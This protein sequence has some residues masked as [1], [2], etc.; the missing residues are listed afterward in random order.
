MVVFMR[1]SG[2][3]ELWKGVRN[4]AMQI[5]TDRMRGLVERLQLLCVHLEDEAFVPIGTAFS[6]VSATT[7]HDLRVV[8]KE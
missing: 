6:T 5:A 1:M 7:T 3:N 8:L 2:V 4:C